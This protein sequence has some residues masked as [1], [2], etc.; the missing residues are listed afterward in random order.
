MIHGNVPLSHSENPFFL[1]FVHCLRPSYDPA[2]RYVLNERYLLAEEARAYNEDLKRLEGRNNLTY[3]MDGWEDIQRRSIYGTMLAEVGEYPVVLG[4]EELTGVRA[5]A[6]NLIALSERAIIKK[7]ITIENVI[8]V[9]TDNPTTMQAF[10]RKWAILHPWIIMLACFM[11]GINTILGKIT[12]FPPIKDAISKNSRIVTFFNSSHYWGGQ[13]EMCAQDKGVTRG[14]KTNTESRF[15]SLILQALSVQE[16]KSAL[17]ELCG[18]DGAQRSIGG[19]TPVNRDVVATVFDLQRWRLTDQLIRICKPLVDI[20]GD[21]ESR[22]SSL[23]DCMLQLIWAHREVTRALPIEGDNLEFT[24]HANRVLTTQFH[25]MNTDIHWLTLFLHPLCRKLAISSAIHSRSLEDAY[26]IALK[27]VRNWNWSKA[28]AEKLAKDLKAYYL[29][30]DPF[31]GGKADGKDWW[32]SLVCN[33]TDHPLKALSIKLFSIVPHA[34]E[35]E[36]FFSNLGGIQSVKRS[37]LTVAHMQTFGMLRNHYTRQL[38]ENAEKQGKSTRRKHAHMHTSE[39]PGI[40]AARAKNLTDTFTYTPLVVEY[41]NANI[42]GPEAITMDEFDAEFDRLEQEPAEPADA[43]DNLGGN[44]GIG[45]VYDLSTLD[46]IR[47]GQAVPTSAEN[48]LGVL[49]Q[50]LVGAETWDASSLLRSL[51]I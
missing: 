25:L 50:T 11:H 26:L 36:R 19:L 44:I 9:C 17:M 34:A 2:T 47:G 37:R 35:V 13:L 29:G 30:Q 6:D 45:D 38:S 51:G 20:I 48:E 15:Y 4:L 40:N 21:I 49:P 1:K 16:H 43:G 12:S 23:A 22:D 10:R 39:T 8:A 33:V 27:I 32:E 5:T 28:L 42:E 3:L 7:E 18:R 14:L 41:S 46:A 24:S 31:S